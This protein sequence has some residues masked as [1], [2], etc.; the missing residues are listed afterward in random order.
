[1]GPDLR[2]YIHKNQ[3]KISLD[4]IRQ[5]AIAMFMS[6][7]ELRVHKV[8]HADIKPDNFLMSLDLIKIKL[9]DFGTAL[10]V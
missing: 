9:T 10:R 2:S 8:I 5:Y 6:L 1:M 7:H 4:N 3:D